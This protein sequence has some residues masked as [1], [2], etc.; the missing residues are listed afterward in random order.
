MRGQLTD[1]KEK[2]KERTRPSNLFFSLKSALVHYS[3]QMFKY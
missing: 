1:Q 3:P 2:E